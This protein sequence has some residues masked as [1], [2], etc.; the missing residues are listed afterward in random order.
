MN[1]ALVDVCAH[2]RHEP[3]FLNV[4]TDATQHWQGLPYA[5][6]PVQLSNS[7]FQRICLPR[8][9]ELVSHPITVDVE[10]FEAGSVFE[11]D[12]A[13]LPDQPPAALTW[14]K[15]VPINEPTPDDKFAEQVRQLPSA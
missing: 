10:A 12:D 11:A 2:M 14:L 7:A 5:G 9:Q 15:E 4:S 8:L 3:L 1:W 13:T 6:L